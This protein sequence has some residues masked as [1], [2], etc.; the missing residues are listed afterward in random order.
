M[1][2]ETMDHASLQP[3]LDKR[4]MGEIA[5]AARDKSAVFGLTHGF[6]R[7]PARFSPGSST[8]WCRGCS[9]PRGV[10]ATGWVPSRIAST[11]SGARKASCSDR[12]TSPTCTPARRAIACVEP[13]ALG[14][15]ADRLGT[16]ADL[17]GIDDGDRD[18]RGD[19][20]RGDRDLVAAGG[21]QHHEPGRQ[22]HQIAAKLL[23]PCLVA[24]HGSPLSGRTKVHVQPPSKRRC[25]RRWR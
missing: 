21:L 5:R 3:G 7:Y 16:G 8:N 24:R 11:R 15:P 12:E 18:A 4:L 2:A 25:R 23:Q 13:V 10:R 1:H 22:R 19:E 20:G 17:A 6:Y 14:Q 9:P